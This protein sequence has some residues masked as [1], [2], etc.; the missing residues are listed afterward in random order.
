MKKT[1]LVTGGSRGIGL[2]IA[3]QLASEGWQV[4]INGRRAAE[5]VQA[6][7]D[8]L[9]RH[10]QPAVYCQ[11]SIGSA[12]ERKR[13]LEEALDAL[14]QLNLL[15]NNAGVAPLE[16]LD[17]LETTEASYDRVMDINLK[18]PFFLSQAAARYLRACKVSNPEGPAAIIN[19]GSISATV[20]SPNRGEYCLSKAGLAMMSRLFAVRLAEFGIPVY[21]VRPGVIRT[22][23]TAG[24]Q[25]KY[26]QLFDQGLA[27]QAR[28]G[29]P[30]DVARCVA[31]LARG[32]FPYSTGD[33]FM[34]DGGLTIN[35]L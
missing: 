14:G 20:V 18:G 26:D 16:R 6:V 4:A 22:D 17:I 15:V 27:V 21:E 24:V 3:E 31:A 5:E 9:A 12:A 19:I 2:A 34:V 35:R 29:T 7:V 1:A 13:L 28:W 33:V 32:D 8:Q 10:G 11:G 23:M 25:Q 30:D